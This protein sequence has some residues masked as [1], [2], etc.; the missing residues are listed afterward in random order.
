ESPLV[1]GDAV[2]VSPGKATATV[3]ALNKNT[4]AEIWR[5][6]IPEGDLAAYGSAI[7]VD[8]GGLKQ[9]VAVLQNGLAGIDA[10]SGKLLWRYERRKRQSRLYSDA[11]CE[12]WDHLHAGRAHGRRRGEI[13]SRRRR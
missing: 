13:E 1:D 3:L 11:G 9:Y 10:H 4:G 7:V 5:C 6:A 12:G 8:Y 2:V